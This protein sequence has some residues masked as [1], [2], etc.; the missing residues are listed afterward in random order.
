MSYRSRPVFSEGYL[1]VGRIRRVPVRVHVATPIGFY[2]L[3]G[4]SFRPVAWAAFLFVIMVHELGHAVLVRRCRL[5][6]L[7]VDINGIGGVCR[8]AGR[9]GDADES[10][11]AWGGILAQ[12]GLLAVTETLARTVGFHGRVVG[13]VANTFV[14]ANVYLMALN[15][16]PFPPLDG[17]KAWAL[18]RWERLH[19]WGRRS[20]LK[21]LSLIH[22]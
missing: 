1:T 9:A 22:I 16:C 10:I 19:F 8:W 20:L 14:D 15:I 13:E 18:F 6:V 5:R 7:S 17:A 11:I 3:T 4:F 2:I 21:V 12:A